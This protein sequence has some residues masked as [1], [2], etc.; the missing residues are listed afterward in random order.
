LITDQSPVVIIRARTA[1]CY[2]ATIDIIYGRDTQKK[3]TRKVT[4]ILVTIL[5]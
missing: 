4:D 3:V 5:K 2:D 1:R